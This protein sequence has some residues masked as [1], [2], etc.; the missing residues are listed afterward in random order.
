MAKEGQSPP[1]EAGHSRLLPGVLISLAALSLAG[2]HLALPERADTVFL[3]LGLVALVPW[4][5]SFLRTLTLGSWFKVEFLELKQQVQEVRQ[6]VEAT[7]SQVRSAVEEVRATRRD[8]VVI[9]DSCLTPDAVLAALIAQ[10]KLT[11]RNCSPGN[12]RTGK[13]TQVVAEMVRVAPQAQHFDVAAALGGKDQGKRLAA[14]ARLYARPDPA[15]LGELVNGLAGHKQRAF[16]QYWGI[17]AVGKVLAV[18]PGGDGGALLQLRDF[19]Q[20]G[21][22]AGTE[23]HKQLAGIL[24]AHGGH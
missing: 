15:R 3:G 10:Y 17:R 1:T 6:V 18:S 22:V 21:L 14:Y 16:V 23:R 4:L 12:P 11:V 7:S 5:A 20:R 24:M 13:L 9:G 8:A 2:A 19:L